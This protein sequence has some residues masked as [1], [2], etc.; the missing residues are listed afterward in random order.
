MAFL[1]SPLRAALERSGDL[2]PS[3]IASLPP[4]HSCIAPGE[5]WLEHPRIDP[6]SYPW[7]WTTAQWR[8]AAELTLRVASQAI[9]AGWTLKDAT[10]LNILFC[11]CAAHSGGRF[12]VRAAR[13]A[14][15]RV[16]GLRPVCA[17]ISAAARSREVS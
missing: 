2:I 17:H 16:A 5:L 14:F 12:V 4:T 6:I 8:A 13:S 9:T 1:A 3:Q 7:E 11:G 15:Q 10:P